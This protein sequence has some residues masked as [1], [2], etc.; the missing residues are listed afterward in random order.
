MVG[1]HVFIATCIHRLLASTFFLL[2]GSA[3]ISI[4]NIKFLVCSF[5]CDTT[6][7]ERAEKEGLKTLFPLLLQH[8][9]A[10]QII[11]EYNCRRVLDTR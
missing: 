2:F 1:S 6:R 4:P 5:E 7:D 8:L 9:S 10:G 3:Q 11:L